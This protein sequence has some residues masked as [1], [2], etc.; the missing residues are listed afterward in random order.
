MNAAVLA[1]LIVAA[2]ILSWCFTVWVEQRARRLG[3]VQHPNHR[4]SHSIPT[5]SGG[6]VA[7]A[8]ATV[9]GIAALCLLAAPGLWPLALGTAAIAALGFADDLR[10]LPA[11][12]RFPVQA[13]ISAGLIWLLPPLPPVVL[14]GSLTFSGLVLALLVLFVGLWWLNLFN[15]MDG[16]DGLAASQ[17]ILILAGACII[18]WSGDHTLA[19]S[20]VFAMALV[21]AAA[22]LGFL[23][24]N[25]PPARIFM[26]DAGSNALALVIFAFAM[27]T[28]AQ[29]A[30][31][32]P[33]W[34]SLPALFVTD[35][36]VTLVRRSLRGER[37]WQ[38]HRRHAYQ[39]LARQ[40]S[41]QRVTLLYAALT[42][43]WCLPVALM[44]Q[45]TAHWAWAGLAYAPLLGF[46]AWAKAGAATETPA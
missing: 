45:H 14:L 39:Q 44:A 34:L 25:W 31:S 37:P 40:W 26:G 19:T 11:S 38:A 36:T 42:S 30:I 10:D 27:L 4:S 23:L 32:Y 16:I 2:A 5:P 22:T 9:L 18:W 41:H 13:L 46:V 43:F 8:I 12:M 3:L 17:A 1:G 35:A 29:G 28:L 15:F 24:R 6:G 21:C 33:A 20:P 7:I